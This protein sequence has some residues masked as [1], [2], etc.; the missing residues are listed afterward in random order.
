V[1][2]LLAKRAE[3]R[4]QSASEVHDALA[5]VKEPPRVWRRLFGR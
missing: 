1:S 4:F 3:D 5:A 2:R